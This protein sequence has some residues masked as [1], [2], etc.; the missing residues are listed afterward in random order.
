MKKGNFPPLSEKAAK[1]GTRP[2]PASPR[3]ERLLLPEALEPAP[4]LGRRGL[5][6]VQLREHLLQRVLSAGAAPVSVVHQPPRRMEQA[7]DVRP[8]GEQPSRS[9]A[10]S[11]ICPAYSPAVAA[12][13]RARSSSSCIRSSIYPSPCLFPFRP[14]YAPAAEGVQKG[15]ALPAGE[16]AALERTL[17]SGTPNRVGAGG[18]YFS[19]SEITW[20]DLHP[21]RPAWAASSQSPLDSGSA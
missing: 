7:V 5:L 16:G 15:G 13:S 21:R 19:R 18:A 8:K 3:L 10:V 20:S 6:V 4:Q 11:T 14:F 9:R 2:G 1:S 12:V 17:I